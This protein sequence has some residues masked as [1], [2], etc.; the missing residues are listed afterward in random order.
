[1]AENDALEKTLEGHNDVFS[2][3]VNTLVYNGKQEVA[4]EALE[5]ATPRSVYK[6][7]GKLREQERDVAKFWR[8]AEFRIALAVLTNDTR[9]EEAYND[10]EEREVPRNMCEVLDEVEN[11]GIQKGMQKG[12]I[13]EYIDIRREDGYEDQDIINGIMNKFGLT[14]EQ[15]DEYMS[16]ITTQI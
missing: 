7:D 6:A 10:F 16:A 3:I 15:A 11:R 14:K 9:F 2:D 5:Q 8:N 4:S 1:M 12:R 13:L